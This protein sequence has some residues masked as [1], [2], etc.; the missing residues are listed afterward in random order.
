[1]PIFKLFISLPLD[2]PV[3]CKICTGLDK[4]GI[5]EKIT[6]LPNFTP[7]VLL[8][9]FVSVLSVSIDSIFAFVADPAFTSA[10]SSVSVFNVAV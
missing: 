4:A 5:G 7:Q 1:M 10:V 8:E 9:K 3:V 2:F 6:L